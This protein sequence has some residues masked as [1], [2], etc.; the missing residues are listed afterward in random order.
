[1]LEMAAPG[2]LWIAPLVAA[3]GA[4]ALWRG[5]HRGRAVSSVKLWRG[6]QG[7]AA[8]Q[9]RRRIDPLWLLVWLS[10]VIGALCLAGPRWVWGPR[11]E[12]PRMSVSWNVRELRHGGQANALGVFARVTEAR[13]VKD[14]VRVVMR[15]DG[16]PPTAADVTLEKLRAGWDFSFATIPANVKGLTLEVQR[17]EGTEALA[18]QTFTRPDGLPFGVQEIGRIAAPLR[19]VFEVQPGATPGDPTVRPL[20]TLVNEAG[21]TA[22]RGTELAASDLVVAGPEV[23]APGLEPGAL[24]TATGDGWKAEAGEGGA[25]LPAYVQWDQVHVFKLR[26]ARLSA[27]W[28]VLARA[29]G[30]PFVALRRAREGERG[31]TWVW[32]AAEVDRETDWWKSPGFVVFFAEMTRLSLGQAGAGRIVPWAPGPLEGIAV[33][34]RPDVEEA[35]LSPALGALAIAMLAGAAGW[36]LWRSRRQ[37]L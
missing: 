34:A 25:D 2:W 27:E 29:G 20:V 26:E 4:W 9:K 17:R 31:P 13:D 1:M 3:A 35:R 19:R 6:L 21:A 32:V 11:A 7:D 23:A 15:V 12:G 5:Q 16:V 22:D 33:A 10:A 18:M 14:P 24:V 30:H 8:S 36:L 37:V 28:Q